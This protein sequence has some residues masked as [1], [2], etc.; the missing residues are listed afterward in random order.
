MN[1]EE[2][3]NHILESSAEIKPAEANPFL[4]QKIIN[5][6]Q[7][8]RVQTVSIAK[9]RLNWAAAIALI[10]A[11]NIAVLFVYHAKSGKQKEAYALQT[12]SNQLSSTTTYRY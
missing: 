4:Y 12:L 5:R 8:P 9:F 11:V 2:R 7:Q 6:V 10:V 1:K 3:I